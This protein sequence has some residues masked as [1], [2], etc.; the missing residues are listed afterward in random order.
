MNLTKE[1][2]NVLH[3]RAKSRPNDIV[4]KHKKSSPPMKDSTNNSNRNHQPP[5]PSLLSRNK[6]RAFH[7]ILLLIPILFILIVEL[8]LRA[9]NYGGDLHLFIPGPGVLKNHYICNR[10]IG[11]RYFVNL[12]Q[13]PTP[14]ND[15][16]QKLKP[17]NGL[18]LFVLGGSTANGYPFG[19]NLMFS[20]ILEAQLS[21]SLPHRVVEVVNVSMTAINSYALLDFMDEILDKEPDAILIYAGHNE[22]YGAL[23]A[24]SMIHVGQHRFFVLA[25]LKLSRLRTF[26]AMR[27]LI[28]WLRSTGKSD[29]IRPSGTLMERLAAQQSIPLH[30]RLYQAGIDQFNGNLKRIVAKA[31]KKNVPVFLSDLVSN[32]SDCAPFIS[33]DEPASAETAFKNAA[34]FENRQE[35]ELAKDEF[36]RAKDLDAL[37]FRAPA[38]F[39]RIIHDIAAEHHMPLVAMDSAFA[40]VS[41]HGLIGDNIMIDHLHPTIQ[42][43]FIMAGAFY[44]AMRRSGLVPSPAH[45]QLDLHTRQR[46]WGYSRLDSLYG[47]LNIRILK[48]GWPFALQDE[49]NMALN[50]FQPH[51]YVEKIAHRVAK[52]RNVSIR[53][54]HEILADYFTA[55]GDPESALQEYKALVA[56]KSYSALP[57]LKLGESLVKSGDV[58][59]VPYLMRQS[60][61]FDESP[62][63]YILLGEAY[64]GL[65]RYL[66]AI[67][68][69]ERAQQ[70]GA[71][72][73]DPHIVVGLKYAYNATGQF[74]RE[75]QLDER[76]QTS[77][78]LLPGDQV[79]ATV[80]RLLQTADQLIRERKF[81]Q[82]LLELEKS[83]AIRE[84]SQAHM[85]IGQIYLEK[86][87]PTAAVEHLEKARRLGANEPLLLYN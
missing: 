11:H 41:P 4:A 25:Y 3:K 83:L 15:Y 32:V 51:D 87:Q 12:R 34:D 80:N 62:L 9:A 78:A 68:A 2:P 8:A 14:A 86:K 72:P 84:T 74:A 53:Q 57:Y 6:K 65:G 22:Y 70:V 23:G 20:R 1:L 73:D 66:E 49:P 35:Y 71:R 17:A 82:A 77:P 5:S 36:I 46:T 27:D 55:A 58:A 43:Y 69:F 85:W 31:A 81:D 63:P 19:S 67:T 50:N 37:R 52:F 42:G 39:N 40:A 10:N 21:E 56:L 61:L 60:L 7:A 24:A 18:R 28:L 44:A 64:N 16:F 45:Q 13:M 30:S 33:I 26:L 76:L 59:P 48:A 79:D 54:G 47:D 75:K 38:E 29:E